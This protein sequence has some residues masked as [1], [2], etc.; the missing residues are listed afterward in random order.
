MKIVIQTIPH[1]NHRYSTCGDYYTYNGVERIFVSDMKNWRYELLIAVHEIIED[2]ICK[3][4]GIAEETITDFDED[5]P[6]AAD[7][8][9]LPDS[10]YR[11]Q[12]HFATGI[13]MLLAKEL[14]VDWLEYEKAVAEL[15]K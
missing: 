8:G 4:K 3:H 10:P 12:H 5:H 14:G 1:K 13:E 2:Y 15:F 11:E 7:P 6:H 9:F